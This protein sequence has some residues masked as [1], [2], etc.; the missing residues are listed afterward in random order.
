MSSAAP[1]IIGA[2]YFVNGI[3]TKYDGET[4]IPGRHA[5]LQRCHC[6]IFHGTAIYVTDLS[7]VMDYASFYSTKDISEKERIAFERFGG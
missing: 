3:L 7:K 5:F 4:Y 2:L 6:G 1:P